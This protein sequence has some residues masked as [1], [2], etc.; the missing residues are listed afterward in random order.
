M[1]RLHRALFAALLVPEY[2]CPIETAID[3]SL[4]GRYYERFA[5]HAVNVADPLIFL[6]IG[7]E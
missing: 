4:P 6:A 5:G 1:D 3:M 7:E 2:P